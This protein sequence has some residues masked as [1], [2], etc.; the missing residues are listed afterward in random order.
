LRPSERESTVTYREGVSSTRQGEVRRKRRTRLD[1]RFLHCWIA[2]VARRRVVGRL[3]VYTEGLIRLLDGTE[4]ERDEP[5]PVAE[6]A[7]GGGTGLGGAPRCFA[8]FLLRDPF[9]ILLERGGRGERGGRRERSEGKFTE[10]KRP[11]HETR[12][13]F[14]KVGRLQRVR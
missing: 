1:V 5:A 10:W 11:V 3:R 2:A 14:S 8:L 12:R 9:A 4:R 13:L 6:L 7:E